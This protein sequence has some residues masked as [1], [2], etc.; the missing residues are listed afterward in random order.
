MAMRYQQVAEGRDVAL[1]ERMSG[2]VL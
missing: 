2:L 1:A